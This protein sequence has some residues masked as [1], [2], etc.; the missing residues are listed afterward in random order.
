M[1]ILFQNEL[2]S[3]RTQVKKSTLIIIFG[4]ISPLTGPEWVACHDAAQVI[5]SPVIL[6]KLLSS[7]W[8]E[9]SRCDHEIFYVFVE[10]LVLRLESGVLFLDRVDPLGEVMES[11]LKLQNV[12]YKL[13]FLRTPWAS[14][15]RRRSDASRLSSWRT[16]SHFV[17]FFSLWLWQWALFRKF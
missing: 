8:F 13:F 12:R 16:S 11:V 1:T 15:R 17:L 14:Q 3:L 10:H 4:K 6:F 2:K 5:I 9:Y 7:C